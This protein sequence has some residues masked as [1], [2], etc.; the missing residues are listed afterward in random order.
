MSELNLKLPKE[1]EETL[2]KYHTTPIPSADFTA[3]LEL[4][5]RHKVK[6]TQPEIK[7]RE[8]KSF[9][10]TFRARPVL[11]ILIALLILLALSGVVYVLGRSLG[12]IP[13]YGIVDQNVAMLTLS[14]PVSQTRDGVTI[15]IEEMYISSDKLYSTIVTKNIPNN[16][17]L[18]MSDTTTVTCKGDWAYIFP[19]GASLNF[20]IDG[21]ASMEPI[22]SIDFDHWSFRVRGTSK[23]STPIN[24]ADATDVTLK[25]PCVTSDIPAGSLPENWEFH[26]HFVPAPKGMTAQTAF[27]VTEYAPSPIPTEIPAMPAS[28]IMATPEVNPISIQKVIDTGDTYILFLEVNPPANLGFDY[29]PNV[30]LFDANGENIFLDGPNNGEFEPKPENIWIRQVKKA[31]I[32]AAPLTFKLVEQHWAS[33]PVSVEFDMGE[34]P[35]IGDEWQINQIIN[36]NGIPKKLKTIR[37]VKPYW[38]SASVRYDFVFSYDTSIG[39]K[40]IQIQ[41]IPPVNSGESGGGC[42]AC[43]TDEPVEISGVEYNSFFIGKV[44]ITFTF[45]FMDDEKS[46]ALDWQP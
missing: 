9:M 5:L 29:S 40:D 46:W 18:P 34:N 3:Q 24:L 15:S 6:Q 30:L 26:L 17:V 43:P 44:Q 16:L 28:N 38:S 8:R 12:Y 45:V 25:I 21:N 20:E 13:G 39:I 22:D 27:P 11:A 31:D 42:S 19:D 41:G 1:L 35:K 33:L 14:E 23:F 36:V 32:S 37:L 10:T 4:E 2:V 7:N